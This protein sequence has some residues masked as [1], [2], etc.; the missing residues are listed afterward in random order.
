MRPRLQHSTNT[1][2]GKRV[3]AERDATQK[4]VRKP[5]EK[6]NTGKPISVYIKLNKFLLFMFSSK[7]CMF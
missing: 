7:Y 6:G 1:L 3:V 4:R 5:M 2:K